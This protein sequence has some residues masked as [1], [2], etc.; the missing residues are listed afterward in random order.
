MPFLDIRVFSPH[1]QGGTDFR[2][3]E[4]GRAEDQ[5][6]LNL[7][8]SESYLDIHSKHFPQSVLQEE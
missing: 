8:T 1:A 6:S 7:P 4:V 5:G 2:A 3:R